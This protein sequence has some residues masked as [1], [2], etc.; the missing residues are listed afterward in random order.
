LEEEQNNFDIA[1]VFGVPHI[2]N[3]KEKYGISSDKI[4][5]NWNLKK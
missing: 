5:T 3:P 4:N 1:S 2:V